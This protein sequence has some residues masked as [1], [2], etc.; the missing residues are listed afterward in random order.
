MVELV[1]STVHFL[2]MVGVSVSEVQVVTCLQETVSVEKFV[3]VVVL[4][5]EQAS[6]VVAV[7]DI[8]VNTGAV[9]VAGA[10][11]V[12]AVASVDVVVDGVVDVVVDV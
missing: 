4:A 2:L 7:F 3:T 6:P 9:L 5:I 8:A 11:A 1:A 10:M 12:S